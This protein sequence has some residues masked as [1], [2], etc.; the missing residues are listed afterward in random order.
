MPHKLQLPKQTEL[1][2]LF[3]HGI[4]QL[5]DKFEQRNTGIAHTQ[6]YTQEDTKLQIADA[7]I[8]VISGFWRDDLLA[9]ADRLC[10]IQ[11]PAAG[12]DQFDISKLRDA[13]V[14]LATGRGG[15]GQCCRRTCSWHDARIH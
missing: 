9:T 10:F 4:F 8:A 14:I 1:K 13:G 6:S 15:D 7:D 11:V 3:A 5:S 12:Y 2:I